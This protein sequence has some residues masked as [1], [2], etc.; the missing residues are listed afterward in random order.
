MRTEA[1]SRNLVLMALVLLGGVC[2]GTE[3]LADG[4][5]LVPYLTRV[6]GHDSVLRVSAMVVLLMVI[7]YALNFLVVGW[8]AIRFGPPGLRTVA[9]GLVWFTLIGQ[10]ADRVGAVA[11]GFAAGSVAELMGLRGEGGWLMPLLVLN[12]IF[13][14]I[15]IAGLALFFLRRRWRLSPSPSTAIA[16]V[17]AVVSNP[18]WAL[19]L[20]FFRGV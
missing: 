10:V 17:A 7:N 3:A 20:L 2:T 11:A 14:G 8:P 6:G 18:A 5:D 4:V 19:G 16:I 15:A 1:I 12:F 13:S 9:K